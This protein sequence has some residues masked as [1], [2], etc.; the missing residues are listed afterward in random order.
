MSKWLS[1]SIPVSLTLLVASSAWA[2]PTSRPAAPAPR[3]KTPTKQAPKAA[4]TAPKAANKTKTAPKTAPTK[5][6]PKTAPKVPA[7]AAP[8][9][10]T[11]KQPAPRAAK[12]KATSHKKWSQTYDMM[13]R[14]KKVGEYV[15]NERYQA[16]GTIIVDNKSRLTIKMLFAKVTA[17][18]SSHCVY[19]KNGRLTKF[20]SMSTVRGKTTRYSG[21]QTD[22]GIRIVRQQGKTKT[23]RFFSAAQYQATSLDL[24]FPTATP[25]VK[26]T[27]K[28]LIIPRMRI[29]NQT[30]S[31]R[32]AAQTKVFGKRQPMVEMMIHNKRGNGILLLTRDGKMIAS[33]M[34]GLLGR[35][36]IR[37]KQGK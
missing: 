24:R 33:K 32:T 18:N 16:D 17:V 23:E 9:A 13:F 12:T 2:A 4:K 34:G 5:A 27:R 30:L 1:R 29:V 14:G 11:A 22:K 6:A 15:R 19:D 21:K 8:K 26:F 35:V 36:E 31:F 3:T 28:Y 20:S 7:K 10:A 25:G 37:I